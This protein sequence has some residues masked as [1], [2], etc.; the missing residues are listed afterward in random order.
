MA[1]LDDIAEGRETVG[2]TKDFLDNRILPS[3]NSEVRSDLERGLL[4]AEKAVRFRVR[5]DLSYRFLPASAQEGDAMRALII[6][7]ALDAGI[8]E[9]AHITP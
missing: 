4:P 9:L 5:R 7:G 1:S 6:G 8:P 2:F 3:V